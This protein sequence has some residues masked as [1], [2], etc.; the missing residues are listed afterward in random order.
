MATAACCMAS[1]CGEQKNIQISERKNKVTAILKTGRFDN[2]DS[3]VIIHQRCQQGST[4]V[5]VLYLLLI[6]KAESMWSKNSV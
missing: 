1:W 6:M 5:K 4:I 3:V 2:I